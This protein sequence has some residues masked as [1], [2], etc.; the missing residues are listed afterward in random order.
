MTGGKCRGDV[1]GITGRAGGGEQIKGQVAQLLEQ[2]KVLE[3]TG[4][5]LKI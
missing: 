2:S 1:E 3:L 5:I 4:G